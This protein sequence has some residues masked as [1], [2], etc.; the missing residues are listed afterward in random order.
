MFRPCRNMGKAVPRCLKA[1]L[2]EDVG[3]VFDIV[4]R[5]VVNHLS[6]QR[7]TLSIQMHF[8]DA[9]RTPQIPTMIGLRPSCNCRLIIMKYSPIDDQRLVLLVFRPVSGK[10]LKLR[11]QQGC[12]NGQGERFAWKFKNDISYCRT[13]KFRQNIS[14][15]AR[16]DPLKIATSVCA[17]VRRSKHAHAYSEPY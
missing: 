11:L 2:E 15:L 16:L 9:W 10:H 5:I 1:A 4:Q 3:Q 6:K 14:K 7:R 12:K 8:A 13:I 17:S